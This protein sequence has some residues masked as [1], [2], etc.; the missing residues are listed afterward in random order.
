MTD[1]LV[2]PMPAVTAQAKELLEEARI[3][4]YFDIDRFSK[5]IKNDLFEL[6]DKKY[7]KSICITHLNE[8]ESKIVLPD[9]RI[10]IPT[11]YKAI[12]DIH[13]ENDGGKDWELY[14][15]WDTEN[16]QPINLE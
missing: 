15:S 5:A 6:Y 7:K 14:G 3:D 13:P 10:D 4:G 2:T 16:M 9:K 12:Y 1:T 11:F 8:T